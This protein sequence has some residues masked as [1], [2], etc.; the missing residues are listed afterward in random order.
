MEFFTTGKSRIGF[1][2]IHPL[3]AEL[4]RSLPVLVDPEG[5]TEAAEQR[6]Y[7]E[8]VQGPEHEQLR[9]DWKAF[10]EPGLQEHFRSSRDIVATDLKNLIEK[11]EAFEISIPL[12]HADAWL[13]VLN[14]A[15]IALASD[16]GFD[17]EMLSSTEPPDLVSDRGLTAFRINL[18][19]FMQQCLIEQL[20]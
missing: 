4:V 15:R 12:K 1:R 11:D 10:V 2:N 7:P 14:Q 20:E 6:F 8:P 17:D 5:L 16:L 9:S 19:A 18:Y 3:L 13:N